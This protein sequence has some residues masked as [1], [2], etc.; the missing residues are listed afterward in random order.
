VA[1]GSRAFSPSLAAGT[2][3]ELTLGLSAAGRRRLKAAHEQRAIFTITVSGTGTS[4]RAS[5][6]VTF[7]TTKRK[8]KH[9]GPRLPGL[10]TA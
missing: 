7:K 1:L 2:S 5:R 10:A 3:T 6:K 8:S 9:H 4:L